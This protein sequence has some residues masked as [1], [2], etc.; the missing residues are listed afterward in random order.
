MKGPLLFRGSHKRKSK[1][2][3]LEKKRASTQK[4]KRKKRKKE[5][6]KKQEEKKRERDFRA[7]NW[8][9]KE[10]QKARWT[11]VKKER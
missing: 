9:K 4:K 5:E 10:K 11:L 6:E 7:V 1:R 8:G 3:D 2:T